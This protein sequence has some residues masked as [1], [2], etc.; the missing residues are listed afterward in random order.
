[1]RLGPLFSSGLVAADFARVD[2]GDWC[3]LEAGPGACCGTAHEQVLKA[4]ARRLA[5]ETVAVLGD[6]VGGGLGNT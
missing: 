1:M 6:A 5:G 4:V 3:L 2:H